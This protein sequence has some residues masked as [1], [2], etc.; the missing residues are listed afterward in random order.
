MIYS[1]TALVFVI[2]VDKK[3]PFSVLKC[4]SSIIV[5][6][7]FPSFI[8]ISIITTK[9]YYSMT[10]STLKL[11]P[12]QPLSPCNGPF[13]G[14]ARKRI[15]IH[16]DNIN[17]LLVCAIS[18]IF[19]YCPLSLCLLPQGLTAP[20]QWA[21][22]VVWVRAREVLSV[23]PPT[24]QPPTRGKERSPMTFINWWTTGPGMPWTSH[25]FT[26]VLWFMQL[27]QTLFWHRKCSFSGLCVLVYQTRRPIEERIWTLNGSLLKAKVAGRVNRP[28]PKPTGIWLMIRFSCM[29]LALKV[30]VWI[31]TSVKYRGREYKLVLRKFQFNWLIKYSKVL[32][33][34]TEN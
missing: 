1:E 28:Q 5:F 14:Q 23:C 24:C 10:M 19:C 15:L 16:L 11:R 13:N 4:V 22:Q 32:R 33:A 8:I 17:Y 25:R 18:H 27:Q 26:T 30:F 29:H 3:C 21:V 2:F 9:Q 7:G 6:S 20:M 31:K 12:G 34:R